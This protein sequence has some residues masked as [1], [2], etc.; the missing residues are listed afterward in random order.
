MRKLRFRPPLRPWSPPAATG[1]YWQLL[2][3][4]GSH[5][6]LVA[7]IGG[8]SYSLVFV[9]I[10]CHSLVFDG[11]RQLCLGRSMA[12]L[13]FRFLGLF[14]PFLISSFIALMGFTALRALSLMFIGFHT[15]QNFTGL[16]LLSLASRF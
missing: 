6:Q 10:H 14:Q 9:G 2:A 16:D 1:R 11:F 5:W 12:A 4:T 15:F 13:S 8:Y 7:V 3:V